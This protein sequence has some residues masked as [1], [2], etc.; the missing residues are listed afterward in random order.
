MLYKDA[1][2]VI[3]GELTLAVIYHSAVSRTLSAVGLPA[4]TK[5]SNVHHLD[6]ECPF[7][8][9]LLLI[10]TGFFTTGIVACCDYRTEL[11]LRGF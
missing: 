3:S 8:Y 4:F 10:T 5:T 2:E 9:Q 11:I 1:V 7:R 6:T